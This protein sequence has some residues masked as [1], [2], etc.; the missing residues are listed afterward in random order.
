[1][2]LPLLPV[3]AARAYRPRVSAFTA[4]F[5]NALAQGHWRTVRCTS[6]ARATFP[7]K[8]V[9]PHCWST[10]MEW[11]DLQPRGLL[12]SWTRVHAAPAV[13]AEEAPYACGIVDLEDGLRIAC[14]LVA[15]PDQP[16]RIG[17]AVDMVVLQYQDGPLF[18][19]RP[20]G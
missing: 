17:A 18:A 8:P 11:T 12:Y 9:C 16:L 19:A 5:W 3:A 15:E 4:P 7:P 6:C 1:M 13:F 10:G 14:R 20:R 2:K